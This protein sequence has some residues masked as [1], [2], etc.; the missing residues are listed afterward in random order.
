MAL[1]SFFTERAASP[2]PMASFL[3]FRMVSDL[4]KA[5]MSVRSENRIV[6]RIVT[7]YRLRRSVRTG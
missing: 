1:A 7:D 3:L 4:H 6:T 2:A 5:K